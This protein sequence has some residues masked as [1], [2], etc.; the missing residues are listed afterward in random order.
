M[1]RMVF[2]KWERDRWDWQDKTGFLFIWGEGRKKPTHSRVP[3]RRQAGNDP[4]LLL[5]MKQH[6][7]HLPLTGS[8]DKMNRRLVSRRKINQNW[9]KIQK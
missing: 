8:K 9:M 3:S 6:R 4:S 1:R 7:E 2:V 5:V